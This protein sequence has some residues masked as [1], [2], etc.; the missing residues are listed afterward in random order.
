MAYIYKHIRKD[1]NEVFYI[2]MGITKKRYY[3]KDKRSKHWNRIV[4]KVG[5]DYEIIENNL[6]WDEACHR[7]K[8]WIKF[9]GRIDLN[10]GL[11]INKTNGGDGTS[12]YKLSQNHKE[13]ISKANSGKIRSNLTKNKLKI[14]HTGKLHTK[15]TKD[16]MSNT[17]LLIGNTNPGKSIIGDGVIYNTTVEAA[18]SL[19]IKPQSIFY[20][21]NSPNWN[22]NYINLEIAK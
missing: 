3:Q 19:N 12:G 8:Y 18:K 11:L 13:K 15:Y 6:S 21:L 9:Y 14:A 10:E 20:R 7:E 1:T 16:K 22:W 4:N 2:G 17:R 5:F